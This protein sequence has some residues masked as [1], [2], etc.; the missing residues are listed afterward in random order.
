M[1]RLLNVVTE[2]P[3][4]VCGVDP[5]KFTVFVLAVKVPLLVQLPP[6]LIVVPLVP[7]SVAPLS[8]CTLL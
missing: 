2:E 7:A 5:L 3:P 1:V 8:I 4:I 6:T